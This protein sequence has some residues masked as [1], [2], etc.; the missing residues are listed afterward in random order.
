MQVG[1]LPERHE[2]QELQWRRNDAKTA[3][4]FS[5]GEASAQPVRRLLLSQAVFAQVALKVETPMSPPAWAL[6]ERALLEA[7]SRAVEAFAEKYMD[8]RGYLLH[9]PRWGTL[10]GPD[11]AIET[12][13]NWT[14]LHALGG[15]DKVLDLYRKGLEGHLLQYKELRTVK[16]ELA[17]NGAYHKEFI[18]MSDWFH[19]GEGMR[20]FLLWGFSEPTNPAL[21][22]RMKRF[23]GM[24]MNEDPEAP[25]YDPAKKIIKSIWTGSKGPMMRKATTYDWVGDPVPGTFHLL[26]NEAG[27][28]KMLN[29]MEWYPRM[30]AHCEEYL[31]SVGDSHLN[32]A[33]TLLSLN[34]YALTQEEKYRN[35]TLE[36]MNAWKERTAENRGHDSHNGWPERR[37][38]RRTQRPVVE[39]HVWLE[40]HYLRR[41]AAAHRPP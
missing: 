19:T 21:V 32:T 20:G 26:H 2:N 39:R 9:T 5:V 7:N 8:A 25:N 35:W 6:M 24:Y 41:R 34:A 28:S 14:L 11:D 13:F 3:P 16:T 33:A 31:D 23:A 38:G 30:L 37:T 29:L 12:Y 4:T 1:K 27:T 17:T 36:Y 18:T 40:L 22:Q 15:S 10:D